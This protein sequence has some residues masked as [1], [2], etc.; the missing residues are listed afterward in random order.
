MIDRLLAAGSDLL[1]SE[2]CMAGW[3]LAGAQLAGR[4]QNL[5]LLL[6]AEIKKLHT[7]Q[8]DPEFNPAVLIRRFK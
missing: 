1:F 7:N 6:A 5:T 2:A 8:P 4:Q 3:L